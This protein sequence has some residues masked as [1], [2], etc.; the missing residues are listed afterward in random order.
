MM[1]KRNI[2]SKLASKNSKYLTKTLK[3]KKKTKSI[4]NIKIGKKSKL[5]DLKQ[6]K[7]EV[8]NRPPNLVKDDTQTKSTGKLEK[9]TKIEPYHSVENSKNEIKNEVE[10][11]WSYPL[12][13]TNSAKNLGV[14]KSKYLTSKN[15]P[16]NE[17]PSSYLKKVSFADENLRSY[18]DYNTYQ[19]P[20]YYPQRYYPRPPLPARNECKLK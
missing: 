11:N 13:T 8:E 3:A 7:N 18:R 19:S 16:I 14:D 20:Q 17:D 5:D 4:I 12:R 10:N 15:A 1:E 6:N 2:S 9:D